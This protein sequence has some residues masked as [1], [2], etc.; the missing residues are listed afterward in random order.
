MTPTLE[1]AIRLGCFV[2]V[3]ALMATWEFLAPRRKL[4]VKKP[5]RWASNLALSGLNSLLL[6]LAVPLSTVAMA[7]VASENRWALL[8]QWPLPPWLS[9]LSR[10]RHGR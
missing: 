9:C 3:L 8:N 7:M 10:R 6:R 1:T 2:G 5:L 4:V